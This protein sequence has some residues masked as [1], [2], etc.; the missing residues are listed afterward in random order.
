MAKA[1][2]PTFPFELLKAGLL[3]LPYSWGS[4][5]SFNYG[6]MTPGQISQV[7]AVYNA[8]NPN[9]S[10]LLGYSDNGRKIMFGNGI[11]VSGVATDV[12]P[13]A[14]SV[15]HQ[16]LSYAQTNSSVTFNVIAPDFSVTNYSAAGII[17]LYGTVQG[18]VKS[19]YDMQATIAT[20]INN[21]TIT[22]E[23]QIDS[24]YAT[25]PTTF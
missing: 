21:G 7:T 10:A 20:G 24:K 15:L 17:S 19:V 13:D 18:F 23:A 16:N 14:V 9:T 1:I 8:H 12:S 11:K 25:L 22:T 2:G 4:D 3:G 6:A 5:G